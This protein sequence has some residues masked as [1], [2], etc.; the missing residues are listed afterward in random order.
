MGH[1]GDP[2]GFAVGGG[3]VPGRDTTGLVRYLL[4]NGADPNKI[5]PP[6]FD[7]PGYFLYQASK[8]EG[9]E[10]VELLLKHGAQISG[11]GAVQHAVEYGRLN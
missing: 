11:S 9:V 1:A 5:H 10:K 6:H 7:V 3:N 8:R 2:L 4:E